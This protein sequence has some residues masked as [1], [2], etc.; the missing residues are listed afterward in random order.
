MYMISIIWSL[1]YAL[2][3]Y[4]LYRYLLVKRAYK[5]NSIGHMC[6]DI[7]VFGKMYEGLPHV[8]TTKGLDDAKCI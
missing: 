3:S 6:V 4:R 8:G 7:Y 2:V 5:G 1:K